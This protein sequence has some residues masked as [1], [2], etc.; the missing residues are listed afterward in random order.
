M[1]SFIE[2]RGY[3][4]VIVIPPFPSEM[5]EL[6]PENLVQHTLFESVQQTGI[7]YISYYG[8]TEWLS[9]D[10][11]YHGF[12]LNATGRKKFTNDIISRLQQS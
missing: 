1:K 11:Y 9:R 6:L 5:T 10:L 12:L 4:S 7:P 8:K 3:H 2:E